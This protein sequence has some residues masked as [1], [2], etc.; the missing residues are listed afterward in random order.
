M[1]AAALDQVG[2]FED[3]SPDE[4]ALIGEV[5][6]VEQHPRGT[7]IVEEGD[8]PSKFFVILDGH[9]TVHREGRHVVDLGPGD[10]FGEVGVLAL[11]PRNATVIATTPLKVAMAMGW[12]LRRA[13]DQAP[14]AYRRLADTAAARM[15]GG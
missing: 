4:R 13:L 5:M 12:D 1:D 3:L 15:S 9:V 11:E 6:R 14:A 8:V 10:F 7:M 2:L